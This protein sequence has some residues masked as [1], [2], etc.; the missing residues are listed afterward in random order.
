MDQQMDGESAD[1]WADMRDGP[2]DDSSA[3][4]SA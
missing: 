1:H 2:L 4:L 3:A